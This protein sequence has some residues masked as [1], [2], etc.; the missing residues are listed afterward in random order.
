MAKQIRDVLA[1]CCPHE[2]LRVFM[3]K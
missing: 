2:Q 1:H 3:S